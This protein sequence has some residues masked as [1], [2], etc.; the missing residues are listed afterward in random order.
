M[1]Q[2]VKIGDL[3]TVLESRIQARLKNL[4]PKG[5][6]LREVLTRIGVLIETEAKLNIR[7]QHLI[8][9][10]SLWRSIKYKLFNQSG[11]SG[12][13]VGSWGIPYA[14]A[15]EFGFQGS[16]SI[17]SHTRTQVVAFGRRIPAKPVTVS[18]H[19]RFMRIRERPYLRPAVKKRQ[20]EIIDLIRGLLRVGG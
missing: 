16:V 17:R 2:I 12:V 19:T 20:S 10:G 13:A 6:E 15:H 11:L 7:R 5:P 14:A 9:T 18:A 8:D 3:T 4:S 1:A